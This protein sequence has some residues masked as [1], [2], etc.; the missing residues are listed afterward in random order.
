[1]TDKEDVLERLLAVEPRLE[2]IDN[3]LITDS[4]NEILKLRDECQ[5]LAKLLMHEY[6]FI[7]ERL[8]DQVDQ[9]LKPYL[10]GSDE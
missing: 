3:S 1:M 5:K 4:I 10:G 7:H 6:V 9:V 2:I 8:I